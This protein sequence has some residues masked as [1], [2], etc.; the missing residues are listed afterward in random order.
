MR[1]EPNRNAR[2]LTKLFVEAARRVGLGNDEHYNGHA[3]DGAWIAELA[4]KDGRR[5]SAYHAYLEPA[6]RRHNL[7]VVTHAHAT[8]L[9]IDGRRATGVTIRRLGGE[10]TLSARS[11]VLAAGAYASPQLLL[12]SGIGPAALLQKFG[13]PV[14]VDSPEVGENL[15]DHPVLP[16][17]YGTNSTDTLLGA[18]SLRE[19]FRYLLFKRGM[20]ASNGVEGFAFTQVHPG[21]VFAPDLELMFLPIELRN[22]FL[23][24]PTR[25]AFGLGSAVVAPRSRGR[26]ILRSI[27]PHVPLGV[28][29]ALL[30]DSEGIDAKVL[31]EGVRLSRRIAATPPLAEY[32]TGELRPGA[33]VQSDHDILEYAST[34]LQTVYH[35]TST[36]RMGSDARAVVDPRLRVKGIDALWVVDASVMP[37]VPRG[38]PNAVVAMIANRGGAWIEHAITQ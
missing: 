4:H 9:I 3:Y 18:E 10:Q 7:E 5:F 33:E 8:G 12:L 34:E 11:I 26:V 15:Q 16:T 24:A 32:N 31:C 27:D 28:D 21:P 2:A 30:S 19:L 36:C 25:H 37:S 22:Q 35:P 1:I 29:P 23:E 17:I 13:I 6:M 20:L 38:H 14:R